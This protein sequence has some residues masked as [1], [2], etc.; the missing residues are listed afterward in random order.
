ME[1]TAER[2]ELRCRKVLNAYHACV[3]GID[4][5]VARR[6]FISNSPRNTPRSN[7]AGLDE[8]AKQ[9]CNSR[10]GSDAY[11]REK[12]RRCLV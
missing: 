6:R 11:E 4:P 10:I 5:G 8:E 2:S 7:E 12:E 1:R 3:S 9:A